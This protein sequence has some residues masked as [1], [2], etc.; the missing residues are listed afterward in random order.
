MID[1][2]GWFATA[3]VVV[4]YWLNANKKLY[5]ALIIWI[6]GDI[7]WIVYDIYRDIY[8]HLGLSLFIILIN[9]YGIY[10]NLKEKKYGKNTNECRHIPS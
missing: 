10:K 4:G 3:A 5:T 1:I 8:P 6:I 7:C 2:L 9:S